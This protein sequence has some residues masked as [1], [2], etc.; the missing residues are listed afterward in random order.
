LFKNLYFPAARPQ[1]DRATADPDAP[2]C[3]LWH[4]T[5]VEPDQKLGYI[6][7]VRAVAAVAAHFL[8]GVFN[9]E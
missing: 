9:H 6:E 1:D 3:E 4:G 2:S 8:H 7:R 5:G